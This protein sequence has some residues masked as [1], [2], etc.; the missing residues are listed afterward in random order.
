MCYMSLQIM[1]NVWTKYWICQIGSMDF[2]FHIWLFFIKQ[3]SPLKT[4]FIVN[5]SNALTDSVLKHFKFHLI[6]LKCSSHYRTWNENE[7]GLILLLYCQRTADV[8][9]VYQ[10][11][12][13]SNPTCVILEHWHVNWLWQ[14]VGEPHCANTTEN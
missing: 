3:K 14:V 13:A 8:S 10:T 12:M 7:R 4:F 1:Q 5:L 2:K 11:K 6:K 9:V